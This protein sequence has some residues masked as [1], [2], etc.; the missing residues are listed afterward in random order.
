VSGRRGLVLL[1]SAQGVGSVA[2]GAMLLV[3][4][5]LLQERQAA[6]WTVPALRVIFYL[7]YVLLAA[8]AGAAADA[9]PKQRV[10]LG[11]SVAKLAGCGLL[12]AGVHPVLAYALIGV[13]GVAHAPARYGIL[14]ELVPSTA[15]VGANGWIEGVTIAGSL[16]GIVVAGGLLSPAWPGPQAATG[17]H[18]ALVLALLYFTAAAACLGI[19]GRRASDPCALRRPARLL[20]RFIVS[21][22]RLLS[23]RESRTAI[24][25]TSLFWSTA[26][27]LQ[28]L[29]IRWAADQL[30]LPLSGA[31]M[32]QAVFAA[33]LIAGAAAAGRWVRA[34]AAL[35]VLPVGVAIGA[36]LI[37][38]A[39]EN[40]TSAA[41]LTLTIIGACAGLLLVPMNALLQLRGTLV[42]EPGRTVAA[43]HFAENV[44]SI[45]LLALYGVLVLL[46]TPVRACLVA[47]GLLVCSL[48]WMMWKGLHRTRAPGDH[49]RA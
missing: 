49:R 35:R 12:L 38:A 4:I 2:D 14:A 15:L 36:G 31:A 22:H 48:S 17:Q 32:L 37:L 30:A 3:A 34:D 1:L 27:V 16:L 19:P 8:F 20:T 23:D 13:G 11:T 6:A 24:G 28:F 47:L 39:W 44:A 26:A 25:V 7:A 10:L 29:V 43:Q 45:V 9:W 18:A 46:D 21:T 42:L 41:G 5:Q 40:R 33:G